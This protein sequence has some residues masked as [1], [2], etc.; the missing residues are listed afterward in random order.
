MQLRTISNPPRGCGRAKE[1]GFYARGDVG[2][3]GTL[4]AWSWVLGEHLIG[5]FNYTIS[6]PARQMQMIHLPATLI[7]GKMMTTPV[8]LSDFPHLRNLPPICLLDHV[9]SAFYTPYSFYSECVQHGPSRRIPENI[10]K[11]LAGHTPIPIMFTHDWL[12]VVDHERIDALLA[13]S[14]NKRDR[15][16]FDPTPLDAD[17]GITVESNYRGRDH[18]IIPIIR[19]MHEASNGEQCH[20]TKI[21]PPELV[22][23][24][25]IAEQ[26]YGISWI[27]S[28]VYVA[29]DGDTDEQLEAMMSLGIEPVRPSEE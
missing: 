9:G 12:P 10:A 24:T 6:V 23:D 21:M 26:V 5:K 28:V 17:W 20:L 18:W 27:T 19:Q 4:S 3:G 22:N 8:D 16:S 11:V 29:K 25:L 2:P 15:L 13:W 7:T 1:G 14:Q